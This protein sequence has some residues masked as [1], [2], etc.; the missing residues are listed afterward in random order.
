MLFAAPADPPFITKV[1]D[2]NSTAVKLTW[3]GPKTPNGIIRYY[4]INITKKTDGTVLDAVLTNNS[5]TSA[6]ISGLEIYTDY[7]FTVRAFTVK[8]SNFS[9]PV[10]GR[11]GERRKLIF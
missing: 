10:T 4:A 5:M 3:T 2:V 1:V 8:Y 11:S 6:T 9:D 7:I